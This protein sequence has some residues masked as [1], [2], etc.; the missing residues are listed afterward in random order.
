MANLITIIIP[1]YN[2]EKY[3]EETIFNIINN[4]NNSLEIVI[5]DDGSS[6]RSGEICRHLSEK[7]KNIKYIYQDN[8]GV[9]KARNN[10]LLKSTGKYV[11]F[12]DQDDMLDPIVFK[13]EDINRIIK[14]DKPDILSFSY[15]ICN[16]NLRRGNLVKARKEVFINGEVLATPEAWN[17]HSSY[18]FN[19]DFLTLNKIRYLEGSRHEDEIFRIKALILSNKVYSF[20]IPNF[21]YRTNSNSVTHL[22]IDPF[23]LYS[24]LIYVWNEFRIW[25]NNNHYETE[26]GIAVGMIISLLNELAQTLQLGGKRSEEIFKTIQTLITTI[27]KTNDSKMNLDL[28]LISLYSP[29]RVIIINTVHYIYKIF[30]ILN[31]SSAFDYFRYR[32]KINLF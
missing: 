9:G 4:Y 13:R 23:T 32:N 22:K 16:E 19:K 5:V 3:I 27:D 29:Y 31:L 20:E 8:C 10:G 11:M 1:V 21:Y 6:D 7:H 15:Y 12:L 14:R 30:K 24:E 18:L 17:H 25:M 26:S 28:S 2:G